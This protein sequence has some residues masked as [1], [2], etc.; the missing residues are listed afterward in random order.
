M[1]RDV[2]LLF[3]FVFALQSVHQVDYLVYSLVPDL[4]CVLHFAHWWD[5]WLELIM[6]RC[7]LSLVCFWLS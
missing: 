1:E 5:F 4:G 2:N 6:V 3:G 7:L